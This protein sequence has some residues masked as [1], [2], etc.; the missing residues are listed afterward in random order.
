MT[1]REWNKL[2]SF[3]KCKE[4]RPYWEALQKKRFALAVKRIGDVLL[5]FILLFIL[6]LPMAVIALLIVLD[7]RG[8]VFFR[9][10]R[11]TAY[12]KIFRIH[13][14]RTM[15]TDAEKKGP[16]ITAGEDE[17]ITKIGRILRKLRLDELP[18]LFDVI[19]GDMS[20]VGTRPESVKY[21]KQYKKEYYA[22]LLM[23]AGIT[24]EASIRYK[25][26]QM[27][28]GDAE[29]VDETYLNVILPEKMKW[30][31]K[32][33]RSFSLIRDMGTMVRTVFAVL[34]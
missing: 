20:F 5:A 4:V 28:I 16:S 3:M 31:L 1:L 34:H 2:P 29:N 7:S 11:V 19:N 13:K 27:I 17:R 18:Q 14:F 6:A 21:V 12:G 33:I 30:N 25:D 24:S 26:E 15:V 9:Q 32:S 8:P 22:T 10:E 23:P